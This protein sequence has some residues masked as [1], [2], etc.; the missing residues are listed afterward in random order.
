M[1]KLRGILEVGKFKYDLTV[2]AVDAF[3]AACTTALFGLCW[4]S[5]YKSALLR[6]FIWRDGA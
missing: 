2:F 3:G 6:R 4:F 1:R 5:F